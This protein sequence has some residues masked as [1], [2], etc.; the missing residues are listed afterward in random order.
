MLRKL[1]QFTRL[2]RV[3][4]TFS[5]YGLD[6]V[7]DF[8]EPRGPWKFLSKLSRAERL[9]Q[10]RG[11]RLRLALQEL[12][13]IYVKFGQVLSTRRDLLPAD[14]A[15]E[16][17]LLQDRVAPFPG[18]IAQSI[19][20]Q[21]LG[22]PV[23]QH[24]GSFEQTPLASASIA[25]VHAATLKTGE[26][27]VIKVLRPGIALKIRSDLD[28][29]QTLATMAERVL[30]DRK[31]I[32]P[33]D[34][35]SE[36][37]RTL[38][39]ELDLQREGANCAQIRRNMRP[40]DK[41]RAP[42]IHWPLTKESVLVMERV[43]G[44]SVSDFESLRAARIDLPT[45]AERAVKLF[46]T[47]VFRDNFFH[48]DMHPGNILIS[49]ENP[50]DPTFILLDFGIVGALSD[51]DQ[52]YLAEN[53]AAMFN[54]N[55]RRVAELHIDAGWMPK[56]IRIDELEGAVRTVCEPYFTRPLA[57]ISL[58]EV[59]YKLFK[60]A[61]QYQLTI[62][63][64]LI[65]LQKTLLNIEGIGRTLH[66]KLDIWATAK[67]ILEQ[68]MRDKYGPAAGLKAL[69]ARVP[70]LLERAPE[71]PE[72]VYRWLK[73]SV[74]GE[75]TARLQSEDLSAIRGELKVA[76]RQNVFAILGAGLLIASSVLFS[77]DAGGPKVF[78]LPLSALAAAL[79]GLWAFRAAWV[80]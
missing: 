8:V 13:P 30:S 12:G 69:E 63:P 9:D 29:L 6:E 23:E 39:D 2:W 54:L 35:V 43:D 17:T 31:R 68:I 27:V 38:L 24:F 15:D 22:G 5:R 65:L 34:I 55:Y 51:Q 48:A 28:L 62:Q 19:I 14:I 46:Y 21:A 79:G 77:F 52:R 44:I 36:I 80:R 60:V 32:R 10:P 25:Q 61:H 16:L 72:L 78:N 4:R 50:A 47:Q 64:Q 57:E 33:R 20:E 74:N 11:A 37:E 67:P 71:L 49:R 26:A 56:H 58:G 7:I 18:D 53:F 41:V 70:A 40:E 42:A 76:Q 59:L 75:Q 66:P 3:L 73:Q 45:I 1:R